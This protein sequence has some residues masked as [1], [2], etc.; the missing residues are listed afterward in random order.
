MEKG[1]PIAGKND[2][3]EAGVK[4]VITQDDKK[5]L[6]DLGYSKDAINKLKP[7]D[8][9][10]I[11]KDQKTASKDKVTPT[12]EEQKQTEKKIYK[13]AVIETTRL[14]E[15]QARDMGDHRMTESKEDRN[16]GW[17]KKTLTRIW[18]H[19][20]FQEYYRQSE[21]S[22][23]RN[24]IL[25]SGNLYAGEPGSASG[26]QHNEAMGAIIDRFTSEYE[27]EMLTKE[28]K[29]TK[30]TVQDLR[31]N[32]DVKNLIKKYAAD[33]NMSDAAFREETTRIISSF[34][35]KYADKNKA[36]ATNLLDIAR[37]VRDSVNH[38][39]KVEAMDFDV[40]IT[41]G[42]ARESLK[43][44]ANF[45][46]VDKVTEK[47]KNSKLGILMDETTIA[48]AVAIA[49]SIGS[50]A[51]NKAL[52]SKAGQIATLGGTAAA[53]ALV[54]GMK[55]SARVTRERAQHAR[56]SAKGM[57]FTEEDMKRRQEMEKAKYETKSA[58]EI[59]ENLESA[60]ARVQMGNIDQ[61]EMEN[62][63]GSLADL[64]ARIR[65]GDKNKIDLVGYSN[66]GTMEVERKNLDLARA[67]LKVALRK[68]IEA[69]TVAFAQ[70]GSF[71]D[72][73]KKVT[74]VEANRLEDKEVSVKDRA[75]TK[76]KTKRVLVMAGKTLLIGAGIG[77]AIQ[78]I[79]SFFKPEQD[80]WVEGAV[81]N[82]RNHLSGGKVKEFLGDHT[83]DFDKHTTALEGLRRMIATHDTPRLPFGL[84]QQIEVGGHHMQIPEGVTVHPN[85]DGTFDILH[86][87]DVIGDNIKLEFTANGELT[88]A[89]KAALAESNIF[90]E[91]ASV[92]GKI[93]EHVHE[94]ASDYLKQHAEG[95]H[96]IHRELWY[97]NDTPHPFDKNELRAWFGGENNTGIDANG[98][99][100]F[101][102]Q[103]MTADGSYHNGLTVD[104]S[105]AIKKGG[106]KMIFSLT[107]D[108]QHQVF[109]VPIDA[110]GNAIIPPN[111][112]IA[113]LMFENKDGHAVFTG[114]FAE[115]AQ[116]MGVAKDGAENLRILATHIGEGREFIDHDVVK[117]TFDSSVK[118]NVPDTWDWDVP[119][120]VP[121]VPRRPLERG[122]YGQDK[123]GKKEKA[124]KA[125]KAVKMDKTAE[126]VPGAV[127][128]DPDSTVI[129]SIYAPENGFHGEKK[130]TKLEV[131]PADHIGTVMTGN[132]VGLN[133]DLNVE[134]NSKKFKNPEFYVF[135]T[136]VEKRDA[137]KAQ[138]A[139]MEVQYPNAKFIYV[140]LPE[141][142]DSLSTKTPYEYMRE[143]LGERA[144]ES[145]INIK[146]IRVGGMRSFNKE[147][148]VK[149]REFY[150]NN[151]K[152]KVQVIES[153]NSPAV[154]NLELEA[155]E[156]ELAS[157][158]AI[159]GMYFKNQEEISDTEVF[160]L[161][162][163]IQALKAT[164]T[165]ST[166]MVAGAKA[167]PEDIF[168]T[169][170]STPETVVASE[171]KLEASKVSLDGNTDYLL[172][173]MTS[174]KT[175]LRNEVESVVNLAGGTSYKQPAFMVY[176][177]DASK[178]DELVSEINELQSK[179]PNVHI[180]YI[181]APENSK[182]EELTSDPEKY[183]SE[184]TTKKRNESGVNAS[185][186]DFTRKVG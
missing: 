111:S 47:I 106:L 144:K 171:S 6:A 105:E 186:K 174:S 148:L 48:S 61:A 58:S 29:D 151:P 53:G 16:T 133:T 89:S 78:E 119:A 157:I 128:M 167:N 156:K 32:T 41:L 80:G 122:E 140:E 178:R 181:K 19:N 12:K 92:G 175:Q 70:S 52:R 46:M 154:A 14:V 36:H 79:G 90:S 117:D 81:K 102:M 9:E 26:A 22:K 51:G 82:V 86:D 150:K 109:E 120:F 182:P 1:L 75:F 33:P 126:K 130:A 160:K 37:E 142:I 18:K 159:G 163:K 63:T 146:D 39:E 94:S 127:R 173:L 24:E 28:E 59:T 73:L 31:V 177:Y 97:D 67:R 34:D 143:S 23:A 10:Q 165:E 137:F 99:Y 96:A 98:N 123:K 54:A 141:D 71:D 162:E 166:P 158:E 179:Y 62:I 91:Y 152:P 20:L 77:I 68:G 85:G 87:K 11:I 116:S 84:G 57:V 56:E 3:K 88:A 45:N 145:N 2:K 43:T 4:L 74:D 185:L 5:Q 121:L 35:Q 180:E 38:G 125:D 42:E 155:L 129:D 15:A 25:E 131:Q 108:T 164:K 100:V 76:L 176:E 147:H 65:L 172:S 114:Q 103:H 110:N 104:A 107:R 183:M 112:E 113:K 136:D 13:A 30:K 66:F 72:F 134:G 118:L 169:P 139:K 93:T 95:T 17:F 153:N 168:A 161:Q 69:K 132:P 60:L 83:G 49:Y 149:A 21:I 55:E 40:E 101:N 138:I 7:E 184:I 27:A 135:E 124:V 44:E 50:F 8:A 115:V 64:E 170:I